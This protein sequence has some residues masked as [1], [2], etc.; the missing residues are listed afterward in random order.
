MEKEKSYLAIIRVGYG[1]GSWC[2]DKDKTQAGARCA[3][4]VKSD[5]KH[6]FKIPKTEYDSVSWD[7]FGF[8]TEVDGKAV[9]IELEGEDFEYT[10]GKK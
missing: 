4:I 5:W 9:K 7:D 8:Y 2:R 10:Y 3:K 6:L 1:G